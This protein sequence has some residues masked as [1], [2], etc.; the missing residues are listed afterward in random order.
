MGAFRVHPQGYKDETLANVKDVPRRKAVDFGYHYK[1]YYQI[2]IEFVTNSL[3]S[4]TLM[5][6]EK[7][8][9]ANELAYSSFFKQG[10]YLRQEANDE[11]QEVEE[12]LLM[13]EDPSIKH[14]ELKE[15]ER[16][17]LKKVGYYTMERNISLIDSAVKSL[18]F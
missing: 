7:I 15:K 8:E 6:V 18:L 13:K 17:T 16:S 11:K 1:R 4:Q 3:G 5:N 2:P 10:D 14:N 9:W 12:F